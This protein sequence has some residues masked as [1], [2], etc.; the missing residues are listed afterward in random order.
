MR[1]PS[2]AIG[3]PVRVAE[4]HPAVLGDQQR[5]AELTSPASLSTRAASALTASA[6]APRSVIF[7]WWLHAVS[8]RLSAADTISAPAPAARLRSRIA[9]MSRPAPVVDANLDPLSQRRDGARLLDR[10]V[11]ISAHPLFRGA[12]APRQRAP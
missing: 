6:S 4:E 12:A 11:G 7:G 8:N 2:L 5:A 9:R 3:R 1:D 10:R